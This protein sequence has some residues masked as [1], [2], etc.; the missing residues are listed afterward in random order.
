VASA[1]MDVSDGLLIDA[2]RLAAASGVAV[3]VD[4]ARMPLSPAAAARTPRTDAA[5]AA[6]AASGDD[7]ELLFTA[8][9][10]V[11]MPGAT[12][13]GTVAPGS[14]LTVVGL[15]GDAIVPARLGYEHG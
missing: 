13:V 15:G 9:A 1:A 5:L 7:Y 11:A 10:G 3:T 12:R 2:G 8:P 4:L 14:G 6:L